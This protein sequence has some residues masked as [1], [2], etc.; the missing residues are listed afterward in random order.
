VQTDKSNAIFASGH[1]FSLTTP[2]ARVAP[3]IPPPS[4][5]PPPPILPNP[6]PPPPAS[7]AMDATIPC[8]KSSEIGNLS[9]IFP[10]AAP[11]SSSPSPSPTPV[12]RGSGFSLMYAKV[13]GSERGWEGGA[14]E[15]VEK[16]DLFERGEEEEE[17]RDEGEVVW[18]ED[19]RER[20]KRVET[21]EEAEDAKEDVWRCMDEAGR[22]GGFVERDGWRGA[23]W[24]GRVGGR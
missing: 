1:F 19:D 9:V 14:L 24:R 6:P 20:E 12:V 11:P 10:L 13:D 8:L 18:D 17:A 21:N 7:D 15:R 23:T 4:P 3:P 5:P 2:I 16:K 22:G